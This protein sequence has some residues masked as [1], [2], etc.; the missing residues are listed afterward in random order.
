MDRLGKYQIVKELGRGGMGVVYKGQDSET[1]TPVAI[2]VLPAQ[3]ALDPVFRQRFIREVKT[4][5]R[6]D[7]PN[8]VKLYDSGHQEGALWYAMEFIEGA[9]LDKELQAQKRLSPLRATRIM[10]EATKALAYC[11]T[12]SV[13]H[14]DIKPA[15]ILLT[16]QGGVKVTDFGIARVTDATR[17]TAT[18]GVLGTVEYMSPEQA[19][20][21]VVDERTDIYS[22]GVVLYQCV[23]GR[24]PITG[25]SP[26]DVINKIKTAQIDAPASWVPDL[27]RNLNDLILHMLEKDRSKRVLSAQALERELERIEAQLL[28]PKS[29]EELAA[30][31]PVTPRAEAASPLRLWPFFVIVFAL[32]VAAGHTFFG[33]SSEPPQPAAQI[34]AAAQLLRD[35]DYANARA[36]LDEISRNPRLTDDE[37]REVKQLS[38]SHR[39]QTLRNEIAAR[40]ETAATRAAEAGLPQIE[41]QILKILANDLSTTRQ[42]ETAARR[43]PATKPQ[44]KP[45]PQPPPPPPPPL[46]SSPLR[47]I[48][49]V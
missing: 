48:L 5:E 3:L 27:P 19:S 34:K 24:L 12:R 20:G 46:M 18:A 42:G 45:P 22:L 38:D 4:L 11:H 40:L 44:P 9:D 2:K 15:N 7:H 41:S 29:A 39:A 28:A 13:I 47:G 43:L 10:L 37:R 33:R 31:L 1:N 21:A 26:A 8:V 25:A 30:A 6:L 23:T 17:M 35:R 49:S 14:R 16:A 36:L 32:G